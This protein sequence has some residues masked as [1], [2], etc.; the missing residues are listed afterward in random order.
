[1]EWTWIAAGAA[2]LIIGI[3]KTSFGGLGS[4][5]VALLALSLP[6]KE[7]T[8]AALLLLITGDII[9][10]LRYRRSADWSL[11]KALLP[12]VVPGILLGALFIQLVDDLVLR[13]SIGA[14]LLASVL[15]QLVMSTLARRRAP[16]PTVDAG[17]PHRALTIG[18]GVAAGFTTMAANAAGPVM[19]VY[20]QLAKVEK[21]RFLGTSAW[22]CRSVNVVKPP[23]TASRGLAA[24]QGMTT[25]AWGIPVVLLGTLIGV[26]LI[27]RVP[28]R[29]FDVLTLL[30]SVIAAGALLII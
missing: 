20:L 14:I 16:D 10:V 27:H 19:A 26:A 11:L 24:P 1:M 4:I 7:S 21:M 5:A 13:R 30:T 3:A 25:V 18:A 22:V 15:I 23:P 2:A 28:Q 17:P 29:T 12:S 6:T 9:G 8:A